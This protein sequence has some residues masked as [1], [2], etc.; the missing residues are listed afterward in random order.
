MRLKLAASTRENDDPPAKHKN[1]VNVRQGKKR[2]KENQKKKLQA[3]PLSLYRRRSY[4][5]P[6]GGL[7]WG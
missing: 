6:G 5:A 7:R 2:K 3:V 4:L 1:D